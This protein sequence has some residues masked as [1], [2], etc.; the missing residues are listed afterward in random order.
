MKDEGLVIKNELRLYPMEEKGNRPSTSFIL[1]PSAF[2]LAFNP[3]A[4]AG[5]TDKRGVLRGR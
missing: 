4:N 3:P 5:G 2:I 1:H